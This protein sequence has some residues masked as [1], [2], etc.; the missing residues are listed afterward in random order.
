MAVAFSYSLV[1]TSNSNSPKPIV[2]HP[3][4]NKPPRSSGYSRLYYY[5]Q[6]K[7]EIYSLEVS[8]DLPYS[9]QK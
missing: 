2:S 5:R 3:F 6:S 1:Y 4:E 8:L 9:R 7:Q